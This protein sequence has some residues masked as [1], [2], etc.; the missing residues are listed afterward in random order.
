MDFALHFSLAEMT[1]SD[2]AVARGIDNT[3]PPELMDDLAATSQLA[4]QVR[5]FMG[6]VPLRVTSG[7]RC[8]A[9]EDIVTNTK[10]STTG[11][12]PVARA[13]DLMPPAGMDVHQFFARIQ[14]CPEVMEQVDQ[15]VIEGGGNLHFGRVMPGHP[16]PRHMLMGDH[17]GPD[18]VRH[19]PLL[20][21][22]QAGQ[23]IHA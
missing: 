7:F 12:H 23:V 20:G 18:G 16:A 2:T 14:E 13:V 21:T 10:G 3:C 1:R 22:W 5:I 17:T 9:V 15:L 4:E 19:Y 8:R 6:G 11:A